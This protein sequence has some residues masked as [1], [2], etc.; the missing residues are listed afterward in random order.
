ML[1]Q[2]DKGLMG[3]IN[4]LW[5]VLTHCTTPDPICRKSFLNLARHFFS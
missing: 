5:R 3:H 1:L 2:I 4:P